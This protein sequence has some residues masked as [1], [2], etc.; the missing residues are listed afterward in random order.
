MSTIKDAVGNQQQF[1]YTL[2]TGLPYQVI[3]GNGRI[4]YLNFANL[5]DE[6]R[7][8]LWRLIS[9]A[10]DNA[11]EITSLVNYRYNPEGDLIAVITP[12]G[13]VVREFAY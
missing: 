5:S 9:V 8:P 11:G 2:E 10:W 4:F 13:K 6:N 3:D 1:I 7:P 12:Q